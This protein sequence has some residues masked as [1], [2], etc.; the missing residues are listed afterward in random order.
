MLGVIKLAITARV[1]RTVKPLM[2]CTFKK[3]VLF[4]QYQYLSPTLHNYDTWTTCASGCVTFLVISPPPR[5]LLQS[6]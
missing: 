6:P 5:V 3:S 2:I 4:H 1:L